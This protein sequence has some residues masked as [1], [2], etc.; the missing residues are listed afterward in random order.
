MNTTHL[1]KKKHTGLG[2]KIKEIRTSKNLTLQKL[3]DISGIKKSYLSEIER[4]KVN[5]SI[6]YLCNIMDCLDMEVHIV[7]KKIKNK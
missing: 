5:L 1:E 7:F 3:A 6:D 4:G 2:H